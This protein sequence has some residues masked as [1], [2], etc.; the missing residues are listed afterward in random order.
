MSWFGMGKVD[1]GKRKSENKYKEER[2]KEMYSTIE[3]SIS[4]NSV[5]SR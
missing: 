4:I 5:K 1:K 2:G 3:V